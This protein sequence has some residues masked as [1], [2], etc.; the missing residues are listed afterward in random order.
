MD[1]MATK[2]LSFEGTTFSNSKSS[3]NSHYNNLNL[4]ASQSCQNVTFIHSK[5]ISIGN[6][7]ENSDLADEKFD[8][9]STTKSNSWKKCDK[10]DL[11]LLDHHSFGKEKQKQQFNQVEGMSFANNSTLSLHISAYENSIES[12]DNYLNVEKSSK[13]SS[14]NKMQ[15]NHKQHFKTDSAFEFPRQQEDIPSKPEIMQ[16]K[17]SQKLLNSNES[18]AKMNNKGRLASYLQPKFF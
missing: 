9:F 8:T 15:N 5:S 6:E 17:S 1:T 14:I 18:N 3:H 10:N 11:Q 16:F 7:Q 2:D 13:T 4:N 12:A